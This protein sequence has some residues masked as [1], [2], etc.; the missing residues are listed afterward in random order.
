MKFKNTVLLV[1]LVG[2]V[3]IV[4][5]ILHGAINSYYECEKSGGY[6]VSRVSH[7]ECIILGKYV[8]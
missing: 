5:Y 3:F 8:R 2:L 4:A 6:L 7:M 1:L